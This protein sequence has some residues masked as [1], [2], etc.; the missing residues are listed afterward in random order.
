M[1]NIKLIG[2]RIKELRQEAALTQSEL[3]KILSV[4]FQA[5]SNWERGI[6]PPDIENL[7]LI[8]EYFGVTVDDLLRKRCEKLY[9]GVDGGG[10]KTEFAVVNE[11]GYVLRRVLKSG[12]NP[13]DIGY[14]EMAKLILGTIGELI[15]EFSSISAVFCGIS[16]ILGGNNSTRLMG[17]IK[18]RFQ[19]ILCGVKTDAYNLFAI[20]ESSDMVVIS[21]TGSVVFVRSGEDLTRLGGHGY[22]LDRAGSAY[23]MGRDAIE[24]ALCEEDRGQYSSVLAQEVKKKLG[25]DTVWES[26]NAIYSGGKAYIAGF[27]TT[28]FT[29]YEKGDATAIDI[30]DKSAKALAELLNLGVER[31]GVNGTALA[32][33]GIFEHNS[34]IMLKHIAKYTDVKLKVVG[35][36]P[37]YGAARL[38][39]A[40]DGEIPEEFCRNFEKSYGGHRK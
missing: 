2:E 19:K 3:A 25:T 9:L 27:S 30:V 4:S 18:K 12:S 32:R 31:C 6:A 40:M 34:E 17:D 28:V 35:L 14:S 16:G 11:D 7:V 24:A 26:I 13:N 10:T 20:D 39:R 23:D 15:S 38:A 5:V 1:L 29:A 36:P 8:S 37:I 21:G 33:G 22:L